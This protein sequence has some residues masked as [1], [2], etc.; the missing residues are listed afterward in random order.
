MHLMHILLDLLTA[1]ALI[2]G[3]FFM[4]VGVIGLLRMP[5]LYN[6]M[7]ATTKCTTLGILGLSL[8]AA[9]NLT[10][11]E[12]ALPAVILTKITLLILFQFVAAPVGAHLLGKAAHM[13]KVRQDANTLDD[14]LARDHPPR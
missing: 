8:A 14:E 12:E 9:F 13:V 10:R 1:L 5:D 7:H 2:V 6:R 11:H 3:L 4:V